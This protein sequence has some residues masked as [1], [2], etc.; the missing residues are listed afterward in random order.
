[1]DTGKILEEVL[2][3]YMRKLQGNSITVDKRCGEDLEIEGY[4]GELRQ[5]FSNLILNAIDAMK[6]GGRLRLR[7]VRAHEWSASSRPGVRVTVA[8]TGNG[9]GTADLPHIFE[10]FYTT[11]KDQG[12]GLGLWLA[13]GIVQKHSGWMRVMSSTGPTSSGTVFAVFLPESPAVANTQAA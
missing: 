8:D 9:I 3:L 12:T 1:L 11:K 13:Y 4:P 5:L 2:Q 10:P 7:V 6:E